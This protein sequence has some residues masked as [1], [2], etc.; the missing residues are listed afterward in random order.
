[1]R[2]FVLLNISLIVFLMLFYLARIVFDHDHR[3]TAVG[4]LLVPLLAFVPGS[5]LMRI[6]RL[7]GLGMTRSI[8]YSL[9]LGLLFIMVFGAVLNILHYTG[10][11]VSP[12]SFDLINLTFPMA[13]AV[14]CAIAYNRDRDFSPG[15]N[16]PRWDVQML[17]M[18][19]LAALLPAI[20]VFG[21]YLANNNSGYLTILLS[22]LIICFTPLAL[23]CNRFKRYELLIFSISLALILHRSLIMNFLMGYDVFSEYVAT[24]IATS[25]GWWNVFQSNPLYGGGANTAL[26]LVTLGPM[27]TQLTGIDTVWLFKSVYP[28]F[29]SFVPVALYKVVQSQFGEKPAFIATM[30]FVGYSAFFVL[31]IQ[32][33]KQQVAEIFL[34]ALLLVLTDAAMGKRVRFA[35]VVV[36]LTGVIVSHYAIG[37]LMMG[38]LAGYLFIR[39]LDQVIAGGMITVGRRGFRTV[40]R[41]FDGLIAWI[42]EQM[43]IEGLTVGTLIYY[44]V[45]FFTWFSIASSGQKLSYVQTGGDKIAGGG[46]GLSLD[47]FEALE[48]LLIDYGTALH[49]LEKYFIITA[50]MIMIIGVLIAYRRRA[51]FKTVGSREIVGL[52]LVGSLLLIAGYVVPN[53]AGMFYFGRFFHFTFIFIGGFFALGLCSIVKVGARTFKVSSSRLEKNGCNDRSIL[54]IALVIL[55]PFMLLNCG[56]AYAVANEI[57]DRYYINSFSLDESVS[58]SI[59]SDKDVITARWAADPDHRGDYPIT[60]D[61]HRFPIF[62]GLETPVKNLAYQWTANQTDSLIYLSDWNLRYGYVYPLSVKGSIRLSYSSMTDIIDQ[63]DGKNDIVFSSGKGA[64]VVYVPPSTPV[65]NQEAPLIYTYEDT[66]LYYVAIFPL[67]LLLLIGIAVLNNRKR[68][69]ATGTGKEDKIRASSHRKRK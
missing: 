20:V 6:F 43:S 11:V 33:M 15:P 50:Q 67:T 47:Q 23:L 36:S 68:M 42:R 21:T 8:Y 45:F 25:S 44:V 52:G 49:N 9:A 30:F 57:D 28:F 58:W 24:S 35:L 69:G 34:L 10:Y 65:T 12:L 53:L 16:H 2:R 26:S 29:F 13:L 14:L 64:T 66:P 18:I 27:L 4:Y 56:A 60:A 37:Y 63:V 55:I 31:M 61:W 32:L 3:L 17:L 48:F 5:A 54:A 51:Q 1:M 41:T 22:L 19:A 7:H 39:L 46:T 40:R 38:V 62:S 59:Y